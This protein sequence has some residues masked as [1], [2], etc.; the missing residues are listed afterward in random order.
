MKRFW[1]SSAFALPSL[2]ALVSFAAFVACSSDGSSE[3]SGPTT[4]ESPSPTPTGTSSQTP[5]PAPALATI[6][7][8]QGSAAGGNVVI[9]TGTN[10]D[11]IN[12]VRFGT[13]SALFRVVSADRVDVVAPAGTDALQVLVRRGDD[14][15]NG[16]AYAY[17][18]PVAAAVTT[19][20]PT[21]GPAVGGNTVV[22]TGEHLA[23]STEVRFG[24]KTAAFKVDSDTQISATAPPGTDS[25]DVVVTG[26]GGTSA[27]ISYAYLVGTSL[28]A[29]APIAGPIAGG[30][31]VTLGGTTFTDATA[32]TFGGL[33]ATS[34]T[35][36]SDTQITAVAPAA[37]QGG[38]AQ[39][40]VTTPKWTSN[41]LT[42]NYVTGP[43]L[44]QLTPNFS[45]QNGGGR[46]TLTGVGFSGATAVQIGTK[47]AFTFVVLSDTEISAV[48]PKG[49][50]TGIDSSTVPV[51]VTAPGG[52]SNNV[53][54]TYAGVP[55]MSY[56]TP[57]QGSTSGGTVVAVW[58]YNMQYLTS[59]SFDNVAGTNF[60]VVSDRQISVTTPAHA[61]GSVNVLLGGPTG[62]S[63]SFNGYT[64]VA[65]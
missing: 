13:T 51:T 58:G 33:P 9:L 19:I 8:A 31:V 49:A 12:E 38:A 63:G 48:V 53:T 6:A 21:A 14:L 16:L 4:S 62:G 59:A 42:F 60:T 61:A 23:G 30:T 41:G 3:G 57:L 45:N 55:S 17:V 18:A 47:P 1:S 54:L 5:A 52:V 46:M 26:P 7:P 56:L 36:D 22:L 40:V 65:P 44:T 2:A 35:V 39:I 34:F 24:T 10:L 64:Y 20:T 43:A 27:P 15:S 28:V 37:A 32:V 25:A 29:V 11:T 50:P